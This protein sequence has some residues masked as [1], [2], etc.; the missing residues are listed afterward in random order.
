MNAEILDQF[1]RWWKLFGK[2]FPGLTLE[3]VMARIIA[4]AHPVSH[5]DE[6]FAEVCQNMWRAQQPG[7]IAPP[8]DYSG[9]EDDLV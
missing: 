7:R 1:P 3:V 9:P 8:G 5:P 2:R 4:N 6:Y